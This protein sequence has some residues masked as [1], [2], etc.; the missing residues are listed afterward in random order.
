[1]NNTRTFPIAARLHWLEVLTLISATLT[2]LSAL[3]IVGGHLFFKPLTML[4]AIVFVA[5]RA[6]SSGGVTRADLLL[7]AALFFSLV[8][9]VFLMLPGDYFIPGLAS[10]LVAHLFYLVLLRQGQRWFPSRRGLVA[11][12]GTGA[13]IYAWVW[14]GLGDSV[15]KAAV[16]TYVCVIALMASQAVGRAT[17]L[18]T[19]AAR[20]V[21]LGTCVFMLSDTLIAI[22]KFV[23]PIALAPLWI[24]ATY[25]AAQML[26]VHHVRASDPGP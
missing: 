20:S 2:A 22:N 26:I 19:P 1:M 5:V 13:L 6:R 12:F 11:V 16:A 7:E 18:G 3:G 23:S 8:G 21:A 9:D 10:F 24:L 4:I 17:V 25:Y 15:L 14:P